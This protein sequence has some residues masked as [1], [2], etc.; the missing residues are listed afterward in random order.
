[1]N[2]NNLIFI[3]SLNDYRNIFQIIFSAR[4]QSAV[5]NILRRFEKTYEYDISCYD[6]RMLQECRNMNT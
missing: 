3:Y 4:Q 5:V 2:F 6:L 1:M